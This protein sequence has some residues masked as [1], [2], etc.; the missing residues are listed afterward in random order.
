[1]IDSLISMLDSLSFGELIGKYSRFSAP[2]SYTING[3]FQFGFAFASKPPVD[4][5]QMFA[6]K[7]G[8]KIWEYNSAADTVYHL[9]SNTDSIKIRLQIQ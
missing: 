3:K 1:M 8:W 4:Y 9:I 6:Y 7:Q 2:L 5:E